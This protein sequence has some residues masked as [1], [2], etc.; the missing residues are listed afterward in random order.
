MVDSLIVFHP[1][2]HSDRLVY[3]CAL[4]YHVVA[5]R[6][7]VG[8]LAVADRYGCERVGVFVD[9]YVVRTGGP[10]QVDISRRLAIVYAVFICSAVAVFFRDFGLGGAKF[11]AVDLRGVLE[12]VYAPGSNVFVTVSK[13][14]EVPCG[15]VFEGWVAIERFFCFLFAPYCE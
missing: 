11:G 5:R 3:Y 8:D 4:F 6:V 12:D 13:L 9:G 7:A 2:V 14:C 15:R 10:V 1:V